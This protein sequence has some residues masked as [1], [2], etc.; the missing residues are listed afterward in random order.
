[1]SLKMEPDL[2]AVNFVR[3]TKHASRFT[4]CTNESA[5]LDTSLGLCSYDT[6]LQRRDMSGV[7]SLSSP[8]KLKT[9]SAR[10]GLD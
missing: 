10:L 8:A 5:D 7:S 4:H 9:A 2:K 6:E 3:I 1:M